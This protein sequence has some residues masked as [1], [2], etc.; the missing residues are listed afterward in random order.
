LDRWPD[1]EK[2][3]EARPARLF[4]SA[5]ARAML[6]EFRALVRAGVLR[7]TA[8]NDVV[9]VKPPPEPRPEPPPR[10]RSTPEEIRKLDEQ[11]VD[12]LRRT[13]TGEPSATPGGEES[14]SNLDAL[15]EELIERLAQKILERWESSADRT[16]QDAVLDRLTALLLERWSSPTRR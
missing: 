2:D 5:E 15:R 3:K 9:F 6:D 10:E 11:V 1:S 14:P 13:R 8:D 12:W 4:S 16:L 7:V